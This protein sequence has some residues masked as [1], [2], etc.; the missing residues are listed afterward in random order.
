MIMATQHITCRTYY[1]HKYIHIYIR[2]R[3]RIASLHVD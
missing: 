3:I 2:I 1:L